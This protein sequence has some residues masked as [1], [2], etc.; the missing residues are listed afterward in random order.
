M[1]LQVWLAVLI[2]LAC[3]MPVLYWNYNHRWIS[4]YYQVNH[5]L[6]GEY[7]LLYSLRYLLI[8]FF[9]YSPLFFVLSVAALLR[10]A[11]YNA[12]ESLLY[13]LAI[14]SFVLV[15]WSVGHGTAMP[16]WALC[17]FSL[18]APLAAKRY[19]LWQSNK[20]YARC[21]QL[22][23]ILS[24]ILLG[25]LPIYIFI[26]PVSLMPLAYR[27]LIGFAQTALQIRSLADKYKADYIWVD[28]WTKASR[29]AW[30]AYPMPVQV[31]SQD[32]S[33]F[34]LWFGNA[35]KKNTAIYVSENYLTAEV[36]LATGSSCIYLEKQP[37][38]YQGYLLN[39][40][41]LYYCQDN[42]S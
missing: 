18:T 12:A 38:V 40:F 25:L 15:L 5:G 8:L 13:Y 26:K 11:H 33:Q 10:S 22:L 7:K 34:S 27:D 17:A 35:T 9:A 30:Y 29:F 20:I 2:A 16:H 23:A 42:R 37:I 19:Y 32:L 36:N 14:C 24:V 1:Q 39:T 31:V 4:F 28:H 41:Y 21:T 6:G 3:I